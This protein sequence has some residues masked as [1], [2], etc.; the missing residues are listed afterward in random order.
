MCNGV[1]DESINKTATLAGIEP[2]TFIQFAEFCYFGNYRS[3]LKAVPVFTRS[4]DLASR[5]I[6]RGIDRHFCC[7]CGH[8]E[9]TI[10]ENPCF[11]RDSSTCMSKTTFCIL[12]RSSPSVASF[13]DRICQRCARK[14][15]LF[16]RQNPSQALWG[17]FKTEEFGAMSMLHSELRDYLQHQ[18]KDEPSDDLIDHARLWVFAECYDIPA[19]R[20]LCLHK[21]HRDLIMFNLSEHNSDGLVD[22]LEYIADNTMES[23]HSVEGLTP[24]ECTLRNLLLRY[25]ICHPDIL[26]GSKRFGKLLENG[27]SLVKEYVHKLMQVSQTPASSA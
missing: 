7:Y 5:L 13:D 18:K 26:R 6:A 16:V 22:L 20:D 15:S 8:G 9:Y 17:D 11:P 19:L 14:Y 27:G 25:T 2:R 4:S 3:A 10:T 12:C 24:G 23:Q 21:L 1:M